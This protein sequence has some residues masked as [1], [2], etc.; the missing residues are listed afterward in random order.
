MFYIFLFHVL[1]KAPALITSP[2]AIKFNEGLNQSVS[3]TA[4]TGWTPTLLGLKHHFQNSTSPAS[5]VFTMKESWQQ[6]HL[7]IYL[8]CL[9]LL[10]CLDM[11]GFN[12]H[13]FVLVLTSTARMKRLHL[14]L[15]P[16][17][18]TVIKLPLDLLSYKLRKL[19]E[20]YYSRMADCF[21][22]CASYCVWL[23]RKDS[24]Y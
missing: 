18:S 22:L 9:G 12:L 5:R 23:P 3:L 1:E 8:M 6:E 15:F 7:H 17:K 24:L 16:C 4:V 19:P 20:G 2:G 10:V 14:V 11:S 21:W 13:L